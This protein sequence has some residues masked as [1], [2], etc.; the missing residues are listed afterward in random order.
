MATATSSRG[1]GL[2]QW[3]QLR[4]RGERALLACVATLLVLAL[5]WLFVWQAL[6]QDS[7]RLTRQLA[8]ASST[9]LEARRQADAIA[10][11]ARNTP[12]AP[13]GD[14]RAALDA[15]L[16]QQGLK[17]NATSVERIDNESLRLTFDSIG[18][19]ALSACLDA[20]QRNAQLR[21]VE[22]VV[23]AR[24][25]PGQARAELTLAR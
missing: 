20:L 12:P 1:E 11:L 16:A 23:T 3:W 14:L 4:T 6:V 13:T 7:E 24:V 8:S 9:L 5:A 2:S 17:S 21:A 15:V 10:G 25:E 18:F 22:L 19:E